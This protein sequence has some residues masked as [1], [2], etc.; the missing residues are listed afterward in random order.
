MLIVRGAAWAS[1]VVKSLPV[2]LY[3][4]LVPVVKSCP[5][6]QVLILRQF[7][8][9]G[10]TVLTELYVVYQA[11][12][13]KYRYKQALPA[14]IF[15]VTTPLPSLI[16]IYYSSW[17]LVCSFC[18][19]FLQ[20]ACACKFQATA[21]ILVYKCLVSLTNWFLFILWHQFGTLY[22]AASCLGAHPPACLL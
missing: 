22:V 11:G 10:Y 20:S 3:A 12:V 6:C 5:V 16:F 19:N 2:Q 13:S 18:A 4:V 9:Q 17:K 15:L 1:A 14:G 8:I 21:C 7:T